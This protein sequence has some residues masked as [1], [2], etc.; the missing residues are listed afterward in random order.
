VPADPYGKP[1]VY[2]PG[3]A[4]GKAPDNTV[5]THCPFHR[6]PG[7]GATRQTDLVARVGGSAE[8]LDGSAYDWIRQPR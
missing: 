1:S 4:N 2:F 6:Q 5:I 8:N 7:A 3:L